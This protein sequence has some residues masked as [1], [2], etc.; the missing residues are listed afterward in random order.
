MFAVGVDSI[1]YDMPRGYRGQRVSLRRKLLDGTICFL[2]KGQDIILLP[3]NPTAN[4]RAPRARDNDHDEPPA[5]GPTTA[6][7]ISFQHDFGPIVD[8]DGGFNDSC[9]D[10]HDHEE[11]DP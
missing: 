11:T 4:A 5:M 7:Q 3:T 1:N 2:H 8:R 10:D 9:P 6:A